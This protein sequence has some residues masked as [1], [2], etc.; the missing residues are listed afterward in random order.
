MFQRRR[1]R[2]QVVLSDFAL[3]SLLLFLSVVQLVVP[4]P[5]TLSD[6]I[7]KFCLPTLPVFIQRV[8]FIIV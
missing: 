3:S 7:A 4:T 5:V 8:N 1:S 6:T 2:Q